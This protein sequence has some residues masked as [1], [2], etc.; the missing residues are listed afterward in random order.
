MR[1]AKAFNEIDKSEYKGGFVV[2]FIPQGKY[3]A[4]SCFLLF[5]P[6]VDIFAWFYIEIK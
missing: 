4:G 1:L 2:C 5:N 3:L 6:M